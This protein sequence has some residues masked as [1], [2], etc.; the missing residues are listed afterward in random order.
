[1]A[2]SLFLHVMLGGCEYWIILGSA[3]FVKANNLNKTL[4]LS[5]KT[6][7]LCGYSKKEGVLK[8]HEF[9]VGANR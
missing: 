7:I 1:M 6:V 8:A 4:Q 3:H 5:K 9:S 2:I